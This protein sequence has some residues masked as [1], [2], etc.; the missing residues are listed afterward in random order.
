MPVEL[1]WCVDASHP[2]GAVIEEYFPNVDECLD[3]CGRVLYGNNNLF[4]FAI[5]SVT[6]VRCAAWPHA[7]WKDP[8]TLRPGSKWHITAFLDPAEPPR[9]R[10]MTA[11]YEAFAML[12]AELKRSA[13]FVYLCQAI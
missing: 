4:E 1:N 8:N 13:R 6:D 5:L 9:E 10:A 2:G 7:E 11:T 3:Y 12:I